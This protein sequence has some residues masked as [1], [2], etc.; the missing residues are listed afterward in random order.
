MVVMLTMM[1]ESNEDGDGDANENN[2][3]SSNNV[4]RSAC[5]GFNFFHTQFA[6][7]FLTWLAI[8]STH[9]QRWWRQRLQRHRKYWTRAWLAQIP[10]YLMRKEW[11]RPTT[12]ENQNKLQTNHKSK[13][14]RN[15]PLLGF[16]WNLSL[17][18]VAQSFGSG[19]ELNLDCRKP[20][21]GLVLSVFLLHV[22]QCWSNRSQA[23]AD[24]HK[25]A[26]QATKTK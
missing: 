26:N 16:F 1:N 21:K 19:L 5:C 6:F 11:T 10:A 7:S 20:P 3:P 25:M 13:K 8:Q 17:I 23:T 9:I 14:R 4:I 15:G 18:F 22:H 24:H 12:K 2:F